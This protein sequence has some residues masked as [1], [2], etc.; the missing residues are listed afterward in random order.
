[1]AGIQAVCSGVDP[2][3]PDVP[4]GTRA[5]AEA[6]S[7]TN[8][9]YARVQEIA[10][11][12]IGGTLT[13]VG[14]QAGAPCLMWMNSPV[15]PVAGGQR[16]FINAYIR[17]TL[18]NVQITVVQYGTYGRIDT[19]GPKFN[20]SGWSW[21]NYLHR[22]A[23]NPNLTTLYPP[24]P[25]PYNLDNGWSVTTAPGTQSVQIVIG[26]NRRSQTRAALDVDTVTVSRM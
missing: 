9:R 10:T 22:V 26:G 5:I 23:E 3:A 13:P 25:S 19:A 6:E 12:P 15:I 14:C 17:S 2:T 11:G 24:D 1:L 7:A 16:L 20:P 21:N 18:D 4:P 8:F